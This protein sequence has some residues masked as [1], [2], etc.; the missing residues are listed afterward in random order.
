MIV[1]APEVFQIKIIREKYLTKDNSQR[2]YTA[3]I[4]LLYII[5]ILSLIEFEC[6]AFYASISTLFSVISLMGITS[7]PESVFR[8][9]NKLSIATIEPLVSFIVMT[10]PIA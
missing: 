3:V 1:I 7:F 9:T 4:D 2:N 8:V 6:K 10:S 5:S